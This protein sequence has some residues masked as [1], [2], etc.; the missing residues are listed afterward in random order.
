MGGRRR[1]SDPGTDRHG[2]GLGSLS[3]QHGERA[4]SIRA[5]AEA[6]ACKPQLASLL[7]F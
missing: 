7:I 6:W 5:L 1:T 2:A 3:P 4:L